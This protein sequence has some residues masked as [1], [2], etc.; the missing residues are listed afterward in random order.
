MHGESVLDSLKLHPLFFCVFHVNCVKRN[1]MG[2]V[3]AKTGFL[4][5]QKGDFI[6]LKQDLSR[7]EWGLTDLPSSSINFMLH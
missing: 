5:C 2:K 6:L 4:I 7:L 3:K 1:F